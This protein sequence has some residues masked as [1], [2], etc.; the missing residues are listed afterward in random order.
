MVIISCDD[1]KGFNDLTEW[2]DIAVHDG[3]A[4]QPITWGK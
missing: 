2:D 3:R 4:G 1:D